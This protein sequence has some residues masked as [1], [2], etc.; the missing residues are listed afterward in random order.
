MRTYTCQ[1]GPCLYK[2]HIIFL[3]KLVSSHVQKLLQHIFEKMSWVKFFVIP[4]TC[5]KRDANSGILKNAM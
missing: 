1:G 4:L 3:S 2:S 5:L